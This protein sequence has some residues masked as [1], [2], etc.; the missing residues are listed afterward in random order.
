MFAILVFR[1]PSVDFADLLRTLVLCLALVAV[2]VLAIV[3][4]DLPWP[5]VVATLGKLVV[6]GGLT[7]GF[8]WATHALFV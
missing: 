2:P 4:G 8:G 7:A 3:A 6:G 5:L 1:F